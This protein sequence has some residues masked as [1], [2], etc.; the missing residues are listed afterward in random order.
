MKRYIFLFFLFFIILISIGAKFQPVNSFPLFGKLIILDPGHGY[1][2]PGSIFKDEYEKDY[3]LE[4]AHSLKRKL[5]TY[6]ANVLL[7]RTG[8]YDLSNPSSSRRKRSDFDNRIKII[9]ED[10]PDAYISLHMNYLNDTKYYGSQVFYHPTNKNN[11]PLAETLQ[12]YLNDYFELDRDY[13]KISN[14]KYMYGKLKPTGVL[15]EYG[16]IS[17][18]KD[19]K[20]LKNKIYRDE[21]SEIIALALI[22]YFV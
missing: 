13:K 16:F 18:S 3:N 9:N 20:N 17:S 5:E 14:D 10:N 6:G 12:K 4:F 19:R 2:D 8:D 15:I 7:T 1:L 22:N 21:L 11:K